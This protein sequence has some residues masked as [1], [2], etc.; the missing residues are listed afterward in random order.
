MLMGNIQIKIYQY[1]TQHD[2]IDTVEIQRL[3]KEDIFEDVPL[4][5]VSAAKQSVTIEIFGDD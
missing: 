3:L 4:N 2:I 5:L 1:I